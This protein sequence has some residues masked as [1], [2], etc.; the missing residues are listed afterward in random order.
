MSTTSERYP[1]EDHPLQDAARTSRADRN[2]SLDALHAV[3]AALAEPTTGREVEWLHRVLVAVDALTCALADQAAGD[4]ES[5]SLLSEIVIDEPRLAPRVERLRREYD[6]VRRSLDS[7]REQLALDSAVGVDTAD[8]RDRL[9]SIARRL[10]QQRAREA[11]LIWE[12]VNI[13]LGAGD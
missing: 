2:A 9:A 10:R 6:D 3:E 11:D 7:L 12:A 13:N 5:A 1:Y 8:V 4:V